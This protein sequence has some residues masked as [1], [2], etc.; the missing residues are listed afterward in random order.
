MTVATPT[1]ALLEALNRVGEEMTREW[2]AR[3]G[4]DGARVIAAYRG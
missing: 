3:A 1:P 2:I 4:E